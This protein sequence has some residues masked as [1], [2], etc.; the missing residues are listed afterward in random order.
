[1]QYVWTQ[2]STCPSNGKANESLD[3]VPSI[4]FGG[5]HDY[6]MCNQRKGSS[7]QISRVRDTPNPMVTRNRYGFR[8]PWYRLVNTSKILN[9]HK[10]NFFSGSL[11]YMSSS[12][13]ASIKIENTKNRWPC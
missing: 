7:S 4:S 13:E 9:L 2:G 11:V 1:M 8:L 6:N 5:D 12:M 3:L 10:P